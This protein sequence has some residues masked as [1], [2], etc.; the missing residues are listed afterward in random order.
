MR[1]YLSNVEKNPHLTVGRGTSVSLVLFNSTVLLL[2]FNPLPTSARRC[3]SAQWNGGENGHTSTFPLNHGL[4]LCERARRYYRLNVLRGPAIV[5]RSGRTGRYGEM[6]H[7]QVLPSN[8]TEICCSLP[9]EAVISVM[10]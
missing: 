6:P 10:F 8:I 4:V 3:T 9:S 5:S 2:F 7:F 1:G